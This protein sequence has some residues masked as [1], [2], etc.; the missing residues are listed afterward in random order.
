MMQMLS[1]GVL[2]EEE[3]LELRD[4]LREWVGGGVLHG[5]EATSASLPLVHRKRRLRLKSSSC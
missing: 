1:D 5:E 4:A 2:D 3:A